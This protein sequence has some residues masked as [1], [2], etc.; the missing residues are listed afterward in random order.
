MLRE[1]C[2]QRSDND[3][4]GQHT[5]SRDQP[6]RT[7]TEALCAQGATE[8][9]E[10]VPYLKSEVDDGLCDRAGDAYTLEDGREVVADDAVS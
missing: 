6:Q 7:T 8:S 1:S 9:K 10:G 4:R 5:A 2:T 3:E